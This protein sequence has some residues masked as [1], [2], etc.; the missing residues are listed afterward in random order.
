MPEPNGARSQGHSPDTAASQAMIEQAMMLHQQGK[1]ADAE[2]IY[3]EVLRQQPNHFDALHLLGVIALDQNKQ[4][5]RAVELIQKAIGLNPKV[6]AAHSNLSKALLDMKRPEE[7]LASCDKAI[8]LAPDFAGAHN[9]RGSALMDLQ[10]PADALASFDKALNLKPDFP[11]A[12]NNRAY[13]LIALCRFKEAEEAARKAVTLKPEHSDAWINL[14]WALTELDRWNDAVAA[15]RTAATL[16]PGDTNAWN[17]LG[18]AYIGLGRWKEAE[19]ACR[20]AVAFA[21]NYAEAWANLSRALYGQNRPDEAADAIRHATALMPNRENL[22]D[23][24][25]GNLQKLRAAV[26]RMVAEAKTTSTTFALEAKQIQEWHRIAMHDL[27]PNPGEYRKKHIIIGAIP[28]VPPIWANVP[29]LM[30]NL[31]RYINTNWTLRDPIHLAAFALWRLIWIHPFD[32]GNKRIARALCTAILCIKAAS[33]PLAAESFADALL[34]N[35]STDWADDM[36]CHV[37]AINIYSRTQNTDQA[38]RPV[39]EWLEPLAKEYL[40]A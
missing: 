7:A 11:G 35:R 40:N 23:L 19:E 17:M 33:S 32:D 38:T 39:E 16:K 12:W 3:E 24:N 2:R 13:V 34:N 6:A 29:T 18:Y 26:N 21:P 31:C 1:F 25:E 10:R 37:H 9:N 36:T 30:D 8:A 27:L 22:R 20:K 4:P 14:G 5:E 28:T 15:C